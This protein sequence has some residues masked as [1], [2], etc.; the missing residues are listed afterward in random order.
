MD[1]KEYYKNGDL[2]VIYDSSKDGY[3]LNIVHRN[4]SDKG[5][6]FIDSRAF[7]DV[8]NS[9]ALG[10]L[11]KLELLNP[12]INFSIKKSNI[13]FTTLC[14]ALDDVKGILK[15][16]LEEFKQANNL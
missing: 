8:L 2:K 5:N 14:N 13:S 11:S 7:Q 4:S 9:D 12:L 3:W 1:T 10:K 6:Y 15:K 16:E